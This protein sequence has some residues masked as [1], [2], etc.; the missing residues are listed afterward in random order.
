M[1][2][3]E[4]EEIEM[5]GPSGAVSENFKRRLDYSFLCNDSMSCHFLLTTCT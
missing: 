4:R 3:R 1:P 5:L 2:R